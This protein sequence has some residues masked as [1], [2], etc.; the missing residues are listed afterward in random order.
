MKKVTAFITVAI[1]LATSNFLF[2]Q[3]ESTFGNSGTFTGGIGM[4]VIDNESY[5][6]INL[7]P[8]IS[9]GNFGLGLNVNLLYNTKTGA[10]RTE[11][12]DEDYDWLRLIRYV[13]YGH[14]RDKF[15]TRVGTLDAA[16]LGHG[17]IMNYYTNEASYDQR[18]IGLALDL[19]F[20]I[21]GFETV[22]NNLGRFEVFGA[23][24]YVRPL[25][26]YTTVPIVK[27]I[28]FGLTYVTD[29]DPDE[30]RSTSDGFHEF[31]FDIEV[32]L[33]NIPMFNSFAYFDWA[34]MQDY[35]SGR[36]IGIEAGLSV[37]ANVVELNAKLERRWLGTEFL[38]S[39][40]NA[41][42][43]VERYVIINDST[44]YRK[45]DNLLGVT[46]ETQGI[47]GELSGFILNTIRLTGNF[48]RLDDMKNSGILHLAAEVPDAVPKIAAHATY[49]RRAIEKGSDLFKLDDNSIAR[50]GLG[51]KIKPYLMLFMD[52]IYTFRY[53]EEKNKYKAQERFEPRVAFVYNFGL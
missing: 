11:D 42:Y 41:F 9:L 46:E 18:K 40:F 45:Y 26:L 51:Y 44:T 3:E 25:R 15:Y 43:E 49:D 39:Y 24:G 13:R 21:G 50:V 31:G 48:Q 2:A 4:A 38:P 1:L 29:I 27:D 23:R 35:G 32:P 37:I 53:D 20:G 34:K 47:F 10:I 36:A 17:F 8:D 33:I 5:F 14:K 28:A 19:D 52:Y 30:N 7:H 22:T 16:R 12:W 6:T